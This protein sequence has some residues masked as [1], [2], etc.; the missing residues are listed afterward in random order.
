MKLK[1]FIG[2]FIV[3]TLLIAQE[4]QPDVNNLIAQGNYLKA[5]DQ[6]KIKVEKDS[7]TAEDYCKMGEIFQE[8]GMHGKAIRCFDKTLVEKPE[9][10]NVR[11]ARCHALIKSNQYEKAEES[12]LRITEEDSVNMKALLL[13]SDLYM[14]MKNYR[15]ARSTYSELLAFEITKP[16]ALS[17]IGQCELRL[18]NIEKALDY[19]EKAY[20]S[21]PSNLGLVFLLVKAYQLGGSYSLA[22]QLLQ[23][24]LTKYPEN[25]QLLAEYAY[26]LFHNEEFGKALEIYG[27]VNENHLPAWEKQQRMGI[28]FYYLD[29][30]RYA[31]L[32]LTNSRKQDSTI[33]LTSYYLSLSKM[34]LEKYAEANQ[35]FDETIQL[36]TPSFLAEVYIRKAICCE[37]E[38]DYDASMANYKRAVHF[39]P[40]RKD[41]HYYIANLVDK[42]YKDIELAIEKF[43]YFLDHSDGCEAAMIEYAEVRLEELEEMKI[44]QQ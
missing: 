33:Y 34:E 21:D 23:D 35:F 39:A 16:M 5:L 13:L 30:P 42:H 10:I 22:N 29:K 15:Q 24:E 9:S 41:I 37:N 1:G 3:V 36:S 2:F 7:A 12:L 44:F 19:L 11:F 14:Q 17:G 18:N 26:S 40:N 4:Q 6:L 8:M 27:K 43:E 31:E 25:Q 28:C 38:Q 20:H 32:M